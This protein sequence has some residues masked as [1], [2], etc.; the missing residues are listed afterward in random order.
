M[1]NP[2]DEARVAELHR[3]T[4]ELGL[5][6]DVEVLTNVPYDVLLQ[7]LATATAGI[8]TMR[9]EHFGIGVV[10]FMAAG[11]VA[12]AHNSAGPRMDIV[13]VNSNGQATGFLAATQE[14]YADALGQV[15]SLSTKEREAMQV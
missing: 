5:Q 12:V 15:F 14:E 4:T 8:H 6:N 11:V 1:C 2:G 7:Q 13:R 9:D 10:E 3:L